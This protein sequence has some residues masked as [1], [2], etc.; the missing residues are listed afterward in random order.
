[1]GELSFLYGWEYG[2]TWKKEMCVKSMCDAA[3]TERM[4]T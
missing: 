1:M 3:F 4:E 2:L